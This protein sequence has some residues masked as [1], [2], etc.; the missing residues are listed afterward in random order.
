M[1]FIMLLCLV[2]FVEKFL[3][4]GEIQVL[5]LH[6]HSQCLERPFAGQWGQQTMCA[7]SLNI[8]ECL[9]G[10]NAHLVLC[11]ELPT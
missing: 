4:V 3:T 11:G 7:A 2:S 5:V 6:R 10:S 8:S 1:L 9:K